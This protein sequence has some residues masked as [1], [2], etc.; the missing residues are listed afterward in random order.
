MTTVVLADSDF[1][2]TELERRELAEV[3]ARLVLAPSPSPSDVIAAAAQ[4]EGLLVMWSRAGAELFDGLPRL[5]VVGRFGTGVDTIDVAE[6][7]RRGIAVVNSG[8]YSTEEVAAHAVALIMALVRRV[9][10]LDRSV[11]SGEWDPMA[12]VSE[13]RRISA[14][15]AGVVGLGHIGTRVGRHLQQLGFSVR[16]YDPQIGAAGI[17]QEDTLEALLAVSDL[18]SLHVPLTNATHHLIDRD[19]LARV[20]PGALL[21]NTSRGSVVDEAAVVEAL[22]SGR[23]AGAALDVFE[24][25]PLSRDSPLLK[26]RNVILTPH[27]A[28]Y[29]LQAVE[30]ARL[31]T[32]RAMA[33]VLR[34]EVPDELVNADALRSR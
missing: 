4:A 31:R 13:I 5:R 9:C 21:I 26:L 29:S 1:P 32:V 8:H 3:N 6:A 30:E 27:V 14:L 19:A 20:S 17:D 25:E 24:H 15:R 23:L 33:Q 7:T 22:E 2:D 11:R 28:Y 12:H 34:G 18:V 10:E 16:G